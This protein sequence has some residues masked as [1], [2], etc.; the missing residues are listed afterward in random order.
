MTTVGQSAGALAAA[1]VTKASRLAM[2][3]P[4]LALLLL[5]LFHAAA[6]VAAYC[7]AWAEGRNHPRSSSTAFAPGWNGLAKTPF[8]GWRSWYAFYT[9]MNQSMI[10][11]AIDALAAKNRTVKGWE[12]K[13][14]L[15]DLGYASA[16][17]DEGWESCPASDGRS[18]GSFHYPNGTPAVN[19]ARFPDMKGLVD[20]GHSKGLKWVV[21]ASLLCPVS[22]TSPADSTPTWQDGL[23][24]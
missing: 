22:H 24:L 12:G 2:L 8:R 23:V 14:S 10:E 17:V 11:H 19:V 18:R 9:N 1:N 21:S 4:P 15:V 6:P 7:N 16:G 3:A 5:L 20:Y 13:V